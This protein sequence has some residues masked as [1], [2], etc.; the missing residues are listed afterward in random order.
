MSKYIIQLI[1][2]ETGKRSEP[3]TVT[4]ETYR[5]VLDAVLQNQSEKPKYGVLV[6]IETN[7]LEE[8]VISKAP[9]MNVE[10]FKVAMENRDA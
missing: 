10:Q 3:F 5:A 2:A 7:N 8:M 1:E 4:K 6:N 9:I